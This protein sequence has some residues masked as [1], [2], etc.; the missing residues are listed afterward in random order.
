MRD[1]VAACAR[2]IS[3]AGLVEGFGHV[4]ARLRASDEGLFA[5]TPTLPLQSVRGGEMLVLDERLAVL[6]GDASVCPLEAPL[7]AAIYAARP[8][9]GAVVRTHSMWAS[10]WAARGEL[11]PLLHG[12]GGLAG[13]IA[14]YDC[15]ELVADAD[16]ARAAAADL[17]G[18]DCLLLR[19]NGCACTGAT[20]GR[21]LVRAWYLEE[22]AAIAARASGG[23]ARPLDGDELARRA[24]SFE[25][26][27]ARAQRWLVERFGD[28]EHDPALVTQEE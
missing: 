27:A 17:G 20:V 9:V 19:G 24:H 3:R 14:L 15:A 11:P 10:T 16:S 12:L 18:A 7:H 6:I 26:E 13:K 23:A 28:Q 1:E 22:R 5:I 21:A 25:A 8:D 2:L 4:S